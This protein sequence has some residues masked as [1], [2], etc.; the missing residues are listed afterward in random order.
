MTSTNKDKLQA[1]VSMS[2]PISP[3]MAESNYTYTNA[4]SSKDFFTA[5][6][7]NAN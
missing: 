4:V 6:L 5:M 3:W 1:V 2:P 7:R